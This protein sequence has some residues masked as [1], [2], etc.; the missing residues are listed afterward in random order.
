MTLA[1]E[2]ETTQVRSV[3][4]CASFPKPDLARFDALCRRVN[5][6]RSNVLLH[7]MRKLLEQEAKEVSGKEV[8]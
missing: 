8:A 3:A 7:A 2:L 5:R 1:K 4:I 6:S